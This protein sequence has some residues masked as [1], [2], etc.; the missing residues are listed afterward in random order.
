VGT[1]WNHNENEVAG[2]SGGF[3]KNVGK[4]PPGGGLIG[5]IALCFIVPASQRPTQIMCG[6]AMK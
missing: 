2:W 3:L 6:M 4:R 5:A 1:W